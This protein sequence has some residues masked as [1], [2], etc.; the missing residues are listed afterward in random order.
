MPCVAVWSCSNG[1]V[2]LVNNGTDLTCGRVEVCSNGSW[3]TVCADSWDSTDMDVVCR[4]L[5]ANSCN[6]HS[7][8]NDN[9]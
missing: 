2:R 7:I 1:E 4:Q 9:Y 6:S 8:I 5:D 3:G